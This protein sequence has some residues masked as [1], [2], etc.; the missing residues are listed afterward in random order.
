[1][2]AAKAAR[3]G[4]A[5]LP[6]AA[7]AALSELDERLANYQR[8]YGG[9][10]EDDLYYR[11]TRD[12]VVSGRRWRKLANERIKAAGQTMARWETLFLV[13]FSGQ[14]LTQG[15]LARLIGIEGPTLVRMLDLLAKEGLIARRQ[16]AT[17]GR[18]TVN[19]IT[20]AGRAV[21]D[22]VMGITNRMRA[23]LLQDIDPAELKVTL[24]VLG[25]V[26]DR[27]DEMR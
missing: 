19:T 26:I 16:S 1:M 17:D 12:M 20:P 2:P 4:R 27:L 15:D 6:E 7:N 25:Q 23:E 5:S 3:P 11:M 8:L 14:E 18:M 22:Q 21:I 10:E 9:G 24:K 13:A